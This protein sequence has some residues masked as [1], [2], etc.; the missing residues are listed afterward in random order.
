MNTFVGHRIF[1]YFFD[2]NQGKT[3]YYILMAQWIRFSLSKSNVMGSIPCIDQFFLG[4]NIETTFDFISFSFVV[5]YT[6]LILLLS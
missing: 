5:T 4:L 6:L 1:A 3:Y 2:R